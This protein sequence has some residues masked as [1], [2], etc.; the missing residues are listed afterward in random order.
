MVAVSSERLSSLLIEDP[1]N[2]TG[3][4]IIPLYYLNLATIT[5]DSSYPVITLE[6]FRKQGEER[7][8]LFNYRTYMV[9][10]L[11]FAVCD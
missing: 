7:E 3:V 11:E 9:T 6:F 10:R 1:D 2:N 5:L 4:R 8:L